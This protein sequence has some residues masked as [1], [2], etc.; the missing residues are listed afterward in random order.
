[1]IPT[2]DQTGN[3][4]PGIHWASWKE[5]KTIRNEPASQETAQ[6]AEKGG[7]KFARRWL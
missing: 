3:L 2:F 1:M 5:L 7:G 4:P 6:R